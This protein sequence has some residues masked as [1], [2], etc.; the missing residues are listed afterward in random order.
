MVALVIKGE[1]GMAEELTPD[2]FLPLT[3]CEIPDASRLEFEVWTSGDDGFQVAVCADRDIAEAIAHYGRE[4][5]ERA[6]EQAAGLPDSAP[7][8]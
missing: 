2:Y 8:Q 3:V 6:R 4:I 1:A 7:P 5:L